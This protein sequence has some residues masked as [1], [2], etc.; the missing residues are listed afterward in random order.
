MGVVEGRGRLREGHRLC[1]AHMRLLGACSLRV[2][3]P[4]EVRGQTGDVCMGSEQA[5][6]CLVSKAWYASAGGGP[7]A[8]AV[9][10]TI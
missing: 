8:A 1:V 6:R 7:R 10:T 2:E 4:S 5:A 3:V 9:V